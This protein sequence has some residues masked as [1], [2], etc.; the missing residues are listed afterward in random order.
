MTL[1]RFNKYE[2]GQKY[3]KHIDAFKQSGIQTDW[4]YTLI[5]EPAEK[6]GELEINIEGEDRTFKLEAGD[7]IFY[8]S[9]NIHQVKPVTKGTRIAAIGWIES[10]ITRNDQQKIISHIIDVMQKLDGTEE[11]KDNVL[12]LSYSYHNLMRLWSK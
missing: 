10:L 9:G 11:H 4:S 3:S 6:G 8:P 7:I 1:P 2:V 5:L 12:K